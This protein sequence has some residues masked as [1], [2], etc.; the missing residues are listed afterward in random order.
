MNQRNEFSLTCSLRIFYESLFLLVMGQNPP[1]VL[2]IPSVGLSSITARALY[3]LLKNAWVQCVGKAN[4]G[5]VQG[6]GQLF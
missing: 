4:A 5:R 3:L 2:V 6:L 1:G